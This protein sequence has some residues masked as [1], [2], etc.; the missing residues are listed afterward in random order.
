[1]QW[2]RRT[3]RSVVLAFSM[4]AFLGA[5]S[6]QS[7]VAI[8]ISADPTFNP[9]HPNAFVESV[10][11]NRVLFGSLTEPGV[12][13]Q[14]APDLAVAWSA[15][16]DGLSWTFELRQGVT[17]HDGEAFDADDEVWAR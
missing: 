1:M 16:E 17:W 5:A 2:I 4:L 15:S 13:L 6:A 14:P 9:W 8:P 3:L 12:D 11:G 10:F 7:S